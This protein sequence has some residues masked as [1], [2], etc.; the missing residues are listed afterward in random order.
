MTQEIVHDM[1][2]QIEAMLSETASRSLYSSDE[3]QD[4]L[5]DLLN[6]AKQIEPAG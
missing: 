6:M 1:I 4:N 5:L 3:L 2:E